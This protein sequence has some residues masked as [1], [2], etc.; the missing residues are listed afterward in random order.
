MTDLA[1][2]VNFLS[3]FNTNY[4]SEHWKVAKRVLRYLKGTLNYGLFY[5]QTDE[6]LYAVADADWGGNLTDRRSYS[7]YAFIL[8]GVVISW[9][10]RK[11]KTVSPSSTESEYMALS[12]A[13]REALYLREMLNEI[14]FKHKGIT[15][16]NDSQSAQKLVQSNAFHSRTKHIDVRHHFICEKHQN[17]DINL[18]Y[19]STEDI[20]AD[21]LTKGLP[22][23]KHYKC[24]ENMG[25]AYRTN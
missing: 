3:Q 15:I 13:T 12:E 17:G 21:V 5:E 25:M 11:Q 7:G 6:E 8:A 2:A 1:F 14:G 22:V 10:A 20:P 4:N 19:M 18:N 23:E 9:E 16:Y 24:I